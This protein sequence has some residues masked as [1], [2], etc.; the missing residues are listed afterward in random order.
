MLRLM[1][2]FAASAVGVAAA[3][4]GYTFIYARGYSYMTNDP[5]ACANCHVMDNHYSAW[6][7]TRTAGSPSATTAIRRPA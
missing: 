7:K 1:P 4:G 3:V 5:G 2:L 6:L